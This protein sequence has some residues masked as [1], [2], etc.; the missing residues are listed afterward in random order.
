MKSPFH[1]SVT[2]SKELLSLLDH[3]VIGTPGKGMLYQ[4]TTSREKLGKLT[5]PFIVSL[6]RRE[7]ILGTCTFSLREVLDASVSHQ[8]VYLR[9]FHFDR[10]LRRGSSRVVTKSG[11]LRNSVHELL[12]G[13]AFM[14]PKKHFYYAYYDPGNERSV[15]FC[16][17]YLF[18]E[19]R[20][21]ESVLFTRMFPTKNP[22]PGDITKLN[23][24]DEEK[25]RDLLAS[26]YNSYTMFSFENLFRDGNYYVVKSKN[27]E[28][29]AGVHI[30]PDQWKM[31]AL[32]PPFGKLK[33]KLASIVPLINRVVGKNFS[34]LS[35]EGIY[36]RK[37]HE[38]DLE[39]LLEHLLCLYK[40]HTAIA[41]IDD[42]SP[43]KSLFG[44][45]NLGIVGRSNKGNK[46]AVI[47]RFQGF[48]EEE[49][50]TFFTQPAYISSIDLT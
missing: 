20:T 24:A 5:K 28:I 41:F 4:H 19:V 48:S 2:P 16:K 31:L 42:R 34:F 6:I 32:K 23:G 14:L 45:I 49:K 38:D 13:E 33:L 27:N 26:Y 21:F 46:G 7:K 18:E 15:L 44:K 22:A 17:Q 35:M 39:R 30:N 11:M 43:L 47:C 8:S 40:R 3:N 50:K 37:G 12:N 29:I 1:V 25:M 10:G 36:C 9:Y